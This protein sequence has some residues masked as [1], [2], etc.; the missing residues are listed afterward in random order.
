MT[1]D[2]KNLKFFTFADAFSNSLIVKAFQT[3]DKLQIISADNTEISEETFN[4]FL[5]KATYIQNTS[6]INNNNIDC[7]K[8][9]LFYN[10]D[11]YINIVKEHSLNI[12][13][14][15]YYVGLESLSH[16]FDVQN[17]KF[18]KHKKEP[19][20]TWMTGI[21]RY[22]DLIKKVIK[23]GEPYPILE[24]FYPTISNVSEFIDDYIKSESPVLLLIGPPGTGKSNLIKYLVNKTQEDILLTYDANI[25]KMDNLFDY[26]HDSPEKYL[27]IEDADHYIGSRSDGNQDM[28][29]LLNITDGLTANK[30]K[31]VIFSTNLSSLSRVDPALLRPG[32]C[33]A[34]IEF[35]NLNLEQATKVAEDIQLSVDLLTKKSYS[36]AELFELKNIKIQYTNTHQINKFGF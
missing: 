36:L 9:E 26:F 18:T 34:A 5:T 15:D 33:F 1:I 6:Y 25:M 27:I 24:S 3:Q 32:R 35:P 14:L 11:I 2:I 19:T 10:S 21:D 28:K 23:I 17:L 7:T 8:Y 13:K 16:V 31:K 4:L 30:N 29:K 22:G 20:V 12:Y